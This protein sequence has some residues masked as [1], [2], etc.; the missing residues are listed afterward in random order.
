[1]KNER[2]GVMLC[3]MCEFDGAD[4]ENE[5]GWWC[6]NCDS[7]NF[8]D[9]AEYGKHR[10]TIVLEDKKQLE[11]K[12]MPL[13]KFKRQLSPLRYPGG[14]SKFIP[15]LASL[16]QLDK[17]E[18]L[19]SPFT[20][21]GSFELAM[22]EAGVVKRLR[23]NDLDY[24]I[25]SLWWTM[26]YMPDALIERIK[27]FRPNHKAYFEAQAL[28]KTDYRHLD[29][30]EAAWITLMVNR[31]AFSGIA[32]ANPLG[33]KNGSEESLV[34]RWNPDT[35]I[36]RILRIHEMSEAIDIHCENAVRF[37]EDYFWDDGATM[38]IDPP[39]FLK[40]KD[41]Y[42]QFYTKKDHDELA[43]TLRSLHYGF[44]N[45]DIIVT[46]DFHEYIEDIYFLVDQKEVVGRQYSI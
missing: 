31:L 46:Y 43:W 1:M 2:A 35:L 39:Y 27:T 8:W 41:L 38:F 10:F 44:P 7:F 26:L 14:K 5:R 9:K 22:L 34:A 33:G 37:I 30:L 29:M 4:D 45:A 6:G 42:N 28:I 36:K 32:K 12:V 23:L 17:C 20:G 3:R 16:L 18:T 21:G 25:Y 13:A 19:I 11:K 40:G 15:Y 24:G